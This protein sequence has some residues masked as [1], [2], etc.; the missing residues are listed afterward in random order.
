MTSKSN[1]IISKKINRITNFIRDVRIFLGNKKIYAEESPKKEVVYFV[2]KLYLTKCAMAEEYKDILSAE[3]E[4]YSDAL[5]IPRINKKTS[6]KNKSRLTSYKYAVCDFCLTED[7]K[8]NLLIEFAG[9][10]ELTDYQR[11]KN[12]PT[13]KKVVFEK[14][15]DVSP[16]K[17]RFVLTELDSN[18]KFDR[19]YVVYVDHGATDDERFE[20]TDMEKFSDTIGY[21]IDSH[22]AKLV[23][24]IID[25]KK[26]YPII[27]LDV[28]ED[29]FEFTIIDLAEYCF[30]S[31]VHNDTDFVGTISEKSPA[32]PFDE[33]RWRFFAYLS[34]VLAQDAQDA[35][36]GY[37]YFEQYNKT[38]RRQ[39]ADTLFKDATM[40]LD[41]AREIEVSLLRN[42]PG[43]SY[44]QKNQR[45]KWLRAKK[46][47]TMADGRKRPTDSLRT[48]T[49]RLADKLFKRKPNLGVG[50]IT[51][52]I[53]GAIAGIAEK[54]NIDL[55]LKSENRLVEG[56]VFMARKNPFEKVSYS[57]LKDF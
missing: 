54:N 36:E 12:R 51:T 41:H 44:L 48:L 40:I 37:A 46:A 18:L 20:F 26:K 38:D 33:Q 35:L 29:Q 24:E 53:S 21:Y 3:I 50:E 28:E 56:W 13:L 15:K 34:I 7:K 47:V 11:G 6:K 25:R 42:I 1:D 22:G 43:E 4:G 31:R 30:E 5:K 57:V 10:A 8:K 23:E 39:I 32:P 2:D 9:L 49:I 52:M 27:E 55:N 17:D 45:E 14:D 19:A 16:A